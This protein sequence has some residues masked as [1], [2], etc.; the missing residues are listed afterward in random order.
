MKYTKCLSPSF[1]IYVI[2]TTMVCC[3]TK[4]FPY[5]IDSSPSDRAD[6]QLFKEL[7]VRSRSFDL[8]P[9][10]IWNS[11]HSYNTSP[12]ILIQSDSTKVPLARRYTY[13]INVS[14]WLDI[15]K[16]KK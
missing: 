6:E 3:S 14:K 1:I 2:S 12:L 7:S 15:S 13:L 16:C 5:V 9:E 4:K 10:K 8:A 11:A